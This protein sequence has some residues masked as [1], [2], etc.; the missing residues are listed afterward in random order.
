MPLLFTR[1]TLA[2]AFPIALVTSSPTRNIGLCRSSGRPAELSHVY[3]FAAMAC[4]WI[5]MP[6]KAHGLALCN[7]ICLP[8]VVS[9]SMTLKWC[10]SVSRNSRSLSFPCKIY[11]ESDK[12]NGFCL[13][14]CSDQIES[15]SI[16]ASRGLIDDKISGICQFSRS[17][18]DSL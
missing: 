3:T 5:C 11:F 8:L 10:C 17:K 14:T 7:H 18:K 16:E 4:H 15:R 9:N 2:L 13:K 6:V 1:P 12:R